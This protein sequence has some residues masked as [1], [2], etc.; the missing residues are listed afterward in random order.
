M[1]SHPGVH[2]FTARVLA[3]C[4]VLALSIG[5][6]SVQSSQSV[7]KPRINTLGLRG[8]AI[9]GYDPVAY[10]RKGAPARGS[11][12]FSLKHAGVEW[13]FSSA[14]NK[15]TFAANPAKYMPAYGGYCAYGVSRGYLVKI[16]PNAWAIR[17][18]KLYLN[19]DRSVQRT[20][21][22]KPG[23]YIARANKKWPRLIGK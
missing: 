22:R 1:R 2:K 19:Y 8:V 13:R 17:G 7:A 4:A 10:F 21:S 15:A 3:A 16:E 9:K 20:W 14:E 6:L 18:G 23:T 5:V 11:K 12:K